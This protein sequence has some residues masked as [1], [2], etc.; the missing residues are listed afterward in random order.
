MLAPPYDP[1]TLPLIVPGPH[2]DVIKYTTA[3]VQ[4][5]LNFSPT[6]TGGT[7]TL[8]FNGQTTAPINW[9]ANNT[10]L[11][12]NIQIALNALTNVGQGNMVVS[13]AANPTITYENALSGANQPALTFNGAG[14][15]GGTITSISTSIIGSP[16]NPL[17]F[18]IPQAINDPHTNIAV[19]GVLNVP[20]VIANAPANQVLTGLTVRVDIQHPLASDLSL[21]L[22]A[23]NGT[24]ILLSSG[25]NPLVVR[26]TTTAPRLTIT[27]PCPLPLLP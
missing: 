1:A 14:L 11:Q 22:V 2:Q 9:N 6:T 7:F 5:T 10:V 27:P 18:A 13:A 19:P 25:N 20:L 3:N 26:P 8:S 21:S 24:V 4:E 15:I 12:E 23:P 16:T 17:N